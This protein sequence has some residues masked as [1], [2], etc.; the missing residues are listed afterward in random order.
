MIYE[1]KYRHCT[2]DTEEHID[3]RDDNLGDS[4]HIDVARAELA[5]LYTEDIV[6]VIGGVSSI[7]F[8]FI[9][10]RINIP[11]SCIRTCICTSSIR[12]YSFGKRTTIFRVS[13]SY[14]FISIRINKGSFIRSC[15]YFGICF[16]LTRI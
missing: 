1:G 7:G 15:I 10:D 4:I 11:I 14:M 8:S 5:R 6:S 12:M 9:C 13:S 3:D 16:L 2:R